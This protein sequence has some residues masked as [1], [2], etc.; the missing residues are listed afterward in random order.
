MIRICIGAGLVA[1]GLGAAA[2]AQSQQ[3][4]PERSIVNL[5]GDVYRFQNDQHF[6]VFMVTPD[7]VVV[8]DPINADA[9]TWLKAE[10]AERFD[11]PVKVVA[12]SHHHFDHA[13]GGAVFED[14][15][16][17]VAQQD[18]LDNLAAIR[19]EDAPAQ[20]RDLYA[21]VRAPN[22]L[23]AD[24]QTVTLGGKTMELHAVGGAHASDM[25]YAYFPEEKVLFVV[26]VI[27]IRRLA[28]RDMPGFEFSDMDE[29]V[30]T[31]L[32]FDADIVTP[33]HGDVGT[34]ADVEAFRQYHVDLRDGVQAGIDAGQ[35][36]EEIQASLTLDDYAD[37]GAYE[38]W[39]ALNVEGMYGYLSSTE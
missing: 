21:D 3:A 31:A 29:L 10:I 15:A 14:T 7:G 30:N 5:A 32:A 19:S 27:N 1:A 18:A 11:V 9:A 39:R 12:Y 38:E 8:V 26:D 28:F 24:Q 23:Y 17:F 16:V 34:P 20:T 22:L 37:W 13:S 2:C 33:G 6:G 4:E 36:L 25:S 35:S